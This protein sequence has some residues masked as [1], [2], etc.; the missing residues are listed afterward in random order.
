MTKQIMSGVCEYDILIHVL[1]VDFKGGYDHVNRPRSIRTL[2]E[3][4]MPSKLT[5]LINMML[6]NAQLIEVVR[7]ARILR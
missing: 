6:Q 7:Q 3:F 2:Q 5:K 4:K 1:F